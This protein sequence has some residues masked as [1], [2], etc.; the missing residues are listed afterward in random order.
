MP[1]YFFDSSAIVK[2]YLIEAGTAWVGAIADLAAGNKIYVAHIALVEVISA[3]AGRA[4]GL[5]ISA[6]DAT[7]AVADFRH[8]FANEYSQIE[9]TVASL[10]GLRPWLRLEGCARTTQCSWRRH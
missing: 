6:T 2:R 10:N 1:V 5:H 7:K 3:I 8:D 4:R 9:L